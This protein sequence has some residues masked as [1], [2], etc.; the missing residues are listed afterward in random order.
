MTVIMCIVSAAT[1]LWLKDIYWPLAW[2]APLPL[3]WLAYSPRPARTLVLST[4]VAVL[5]TASPSL[6]RYGAMGSAVLMQSVWQTALAI[7]IFITCLT[8][9]RVAH[10]RS[11]PALALFA[12]PAAW[13]GGTFLYHLL[14]G[15][16]TAGLSAYSQVDVPILIQSASVTGI[17]GIEFILAVFANGIAL[18]LHDARHAILFAGAAIAIVASN[19][20]F[21]LWRL[22]MPQVATVRVAAAAHDLPLGD[23]PPLATDASAGVIEQYVT[24]AKELAA[25]GARVIVFPELASVL[26]PTDSRDQ[27]LAPLAQAAQTT[28]ASITIGFADI[29]GPQEIHNAALTFRPGNELAHYYKR[30]TLVPLDPSIR[31]TQPGILGGGRAVAICKDMD[32][33]ATIRSDAQLGVQL[34]IVPAADFETDGWTHARM[35][36]L[37]GV[38][39]GFS[40]VRAARNGVLTVTNDRGLVLAKANSSPT[41]IAHV[42]ADVSMGSGNT[43]YRRWGDWFAWACLAYSLLLSALLLRQRSR[44]I[45]R[46]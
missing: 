38:E 39:N 26:L 28:G 43:L 18:A 42:I 35:A 14:V 4:L 24:E 13:T 7:L 21:G 27:V 2:L 44:G 31:G 23:K 17:W 19:A 30:H 12:Y 11:H 40:M 25:Q 10:R 9:A 16:D 6:I 45:S 46:S 32:F 1:L 15:G 33:P 41:G 29:K 8:L 37:R 34:M 3:L 22:S 5:L 20:L 36:I